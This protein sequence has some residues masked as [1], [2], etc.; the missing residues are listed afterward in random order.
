[1]HFSSVEFKTFF[2]LYDS[3]ELTTSQRPSLSIEHSFGALFI[4]SLW[5]RNIFFGLIRHKCEC[6]L[7][8]STV[9]FQKSQTNKQNKQIINEMIGLSKIQIRNPYLLGKVRTYHN[10]T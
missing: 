5:P 4:H 10:A 8:G 1:M 9:N 3:V 2:H 7:F 6:D